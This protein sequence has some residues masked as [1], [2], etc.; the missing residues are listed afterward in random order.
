[1]KGLLDVNVLIGVASGMSDH[2][3]SDHLLVKA[4][5]TM[6]WV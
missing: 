4:S 5:V 6:C 3:L 2:L 1:M